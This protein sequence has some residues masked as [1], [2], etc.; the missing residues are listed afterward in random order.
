MQARYWN[1][2]VTYGARRR[3]AVWARVTVAVSLMR[4]V[5]SQDLKPGRPI[6][7]S[8]LRLEAHEGLPSDGAYLADIAAAAG[9]LPRRTIAAGMPLRPD[10]L[11]A[12]K[13]VQRGETVQVEVFQGAA[14]LRLEGVAQSAGAVGETIPIENPSSRRRFPARVEAKGKVVVKGPL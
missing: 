12:P 4:V 3:F 1:G 7:A 2:Y 11:E 14:H 5:A 6:E 8:Q 10:W 9:R 13:E